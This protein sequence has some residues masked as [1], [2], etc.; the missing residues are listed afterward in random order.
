MNKKYYAYKN[1]MYA[2]T[3]ESDTFLV[4]SSWE[5]IEDRPLSWYCRLQYIL[6]RPEYHDEYPRTK[7]A[8]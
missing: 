6:F 3:L 2:I 4:I 1:L 5:I 8:A 7:Q